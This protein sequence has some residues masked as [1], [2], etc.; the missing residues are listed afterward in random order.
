MLALLGFTPA[1]YRGCATR[2]KRKN[3]LLPFP[4]FPYSSL[5]SSRPLP[6]P[7]LLNAVFARDLLNFHVVN[8]IEPCCCCLNLSDLI[9][10]CS[11]PLL[12][13]VMLLWERQD[14]VTSQIL[15][16]TEGC[17]VIARCISHRHVVFVL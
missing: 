11:Y 6:S 9:K 17:F 12:W 1:H 15:V 7:P 16:Y 4:H 2:H 5:F 13:F 14:G 8:E 10:Q 3:P